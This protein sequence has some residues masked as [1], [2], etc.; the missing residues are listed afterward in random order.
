MGRSYK[1]PFTAMLREA[2][3]ASREV[4]ATGVPI[5]EVTQ[6]RAKRA[7]E[8]WQRRRNCLPKSRNISAPQTES[9]D[10]GTRPNGVATQTRIAIVGGG[11][12]GIRCAHKLW[13]D[14]GVKSTVY[15][16]NDYVGGRVQTLRNYFAHGQIVEQRGEFISSEHLSMLALASRYKLSLVNANTSSPNLKDTYLFGGSNYTQQAL[17]EDWQNFGWELFNSAADATAWLTRYYSYNQ[18]GFD[19]DHT[20]VVDWINQNV[21][22]G[23]AS[24][25]GKLCY[26]DVLS[27]FG[28]PPE[29]QSA[30]NLIYLLGY[31]ASSENCF[32][33]KNAPLLA[34]TDERYRIA[35]GND[36][37]LT[38]MVNELPSGT[39]Q[40]G[41]QLIAIKNNSD[42]SYTCTFQSGST[43]SDVIADVVVLAVPFSTLRKVDLSRANISSLKMTAINNLRLGTNVKIMMQFESRAWNSNGFTG[44]SLTDNAAAGTWESTNQQSGSAGILVSFPAGSQGSRLASKYGLTTAHGPAPP[45]LVADTLAAMDQIFA[46]TSKTY[47]G[48]A[49]C[50]IGSNDQHILGAWSSYAIGQYTQFAGIE[51]VAEGGI[52]FAG[53]HTSLDFQGFM[54]GGVTSGERVAEEICLNINHV[55]HGTP[56]RPRS[57][58]MDEEVVLVP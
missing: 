43:P 9:G 26:H 23:M 12:A 25:F 15:E 51:P 46:G 2:D 7:Q 28:I 54:E 24:P 22:N 17:N 5:D 56:T 41:Q 38:G 55:P 18:A 36:Q 1:S 6:M 44:N 16:W 57:E 40:L 13:V 4:A 49:Y 58:R 29:Q 21:P 31:N 33:P 10:V 53:E 19:Y 48:L 35:G 45:A 37:I 8:Q 50:N 42:G 30:L 3:A 52:H 32:Q 39:I 11:L 27:E 47:N 20:S 14:R 34:D